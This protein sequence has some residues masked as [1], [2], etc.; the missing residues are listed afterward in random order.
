MQVLLV[1]PRFP[2]SFWSFD[3]AM[4]LVGR[5]AVLPPLGLITVA[6]ILPDRW[7]LKLVDCNIREVRDAEWDWADVVIISGMIVQKDDMHAQIAEA[8]RRQKLVAVGGPYPT[9]L[10]QDL[11]AA[12]ADFLVLDEGELTLPM[13]VEAIERGETSGTFRSEIKPDVTETP[14][15]VTTCWNWMRTIIC[16]C[17][18]PEVAPINV[19]F[20]TLS[21][22]MVVNPVPKSHNN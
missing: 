1:Y 22:S 6:G 19:N 7:Q 4:E 20:V 16:P 18:S 2:Q 12:G 9:S 8:K 14:I 21:F 5:K 10:P 17:S 15:P 3:K 11:D 13:F